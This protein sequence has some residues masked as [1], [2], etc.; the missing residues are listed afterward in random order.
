MVASTSLIV[1]RKIDDVNLEVCQ[2]RER[3]A[4]GM[5]LAWFS[6]RRVGRLKFETG[7]NAHS[8]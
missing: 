8:N 7:E 4:R 3:R 6:F 5:I 2:H 1:E